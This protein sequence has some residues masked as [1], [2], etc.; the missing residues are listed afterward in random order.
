MSQLR[1]PHSRGRWLKNPMHCLIDSGTAVIWSPGTLT[2]ST[3]RPKDLA[4][5]ASSSLLPRKR[6]SWFPKFHLRQCR[7]RFRCGEHVLQFLVEQAKYA[8]LTI[9]SAQDPRHDNETGIPKWLSLVPIVGPERKPAVQKKNRRPFQVAGPLIYPGRQAKTAGLIVD[10]LYARRRQF[11][12]SRLRSR[13]LAHQSGAE[14]FARLDVVFC[15]SGK[16]SRRQEAIGQNANASANQDGKHGTD[17]EN[18]KQGP[19]APARL[20]LAPPRFVAVELVIHHGLD[21]LA[22]LAGFAPFPLCIRSGIT[23][24]CS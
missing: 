6:I 4:W 17:A 24:Q 9:F 5:R 18:S 11:M 7:E 22:F 23:L 8:G 2:A 1:R 13:S 3:S 19:A 16:G 10:L 14:V 20:G 15:L 12:S 21:K